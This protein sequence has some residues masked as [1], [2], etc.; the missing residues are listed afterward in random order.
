[1]KIFCRIFRIYFNKLMNED[2]I[3][4]LLIAK[5]ISWNNNLRF[6]KIFTSI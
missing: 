6:L 2:S 4:P 3:G 5:D 1:M